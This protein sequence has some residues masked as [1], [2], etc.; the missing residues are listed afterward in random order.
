MSLESQEP[1]P[2]SRR[3]KLEKLFL[4]GVKKERRIREGVDYT[5]QGAMRDFTYLCPAVPDGPHGADAH[6]RQLLSLHT[7]SNANSSENIFTIT[8]R[9]DPSPATVPF[10]TVR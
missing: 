7:E 6:W 8:L 5:A 4:K 2:N 3:K 9:N 1:S 10:N